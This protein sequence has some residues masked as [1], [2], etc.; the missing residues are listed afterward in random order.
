MTTPTPRIHEYYNALVGRGR[1]VVAPTISEARR[2]LRR[3]TEA[4]LH[5]HGI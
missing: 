4:E 5:F 1:H 3:A 2:D